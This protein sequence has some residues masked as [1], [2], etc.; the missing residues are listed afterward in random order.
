MDILT[1]IGVNNISFI[2]ILLIYYILFWVICKLFKKQKT[3]DFVLCMIVFLYS[4]LGKIFEGSFLTNWNVESLGLIY[5]M[6]IYYM[7]PQLKKLNKLKHIIITGITSAIL[8][9]I[10]IKY[11]TVYLLSTY[12][13]RAILAI[14]IIL[15]LTI[16]FNKIEIKSKIIRYI[17]NISYEI[18]L[19]HGIVITLLLN[20]NIPSVI[21]VLLTLVITIITASILN[22]ID[23]KIIEQIKDN[24]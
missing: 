17:G 1:I 23:K 12:V 4:L 21:W 9:I 15:F 6:L 16:I 5:G 8:G 3:R 13:L 14:N 18:Y 19:M 7:I 20:V 2:T 10:Y 11:K 24:S 22:T